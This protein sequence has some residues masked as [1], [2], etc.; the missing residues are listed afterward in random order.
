M[1][2]SFAAN[3]GKE[4]EDNGDQ[5]D[6]FDPFPPWLVILFKPVFLRLGLGLLGDERNTLSEFWRTMLGCSGCTMLRSRMLSACSWALSL[7]S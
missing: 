5:L 1:I 7:A 2:G 4:G 6:W 3:V